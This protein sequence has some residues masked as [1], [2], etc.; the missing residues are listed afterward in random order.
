MDELVGPAP[1]GALDRGVELGESRAYPLGAGERDDGHGS[2]FPDQRG[3]PEPK[4][5]PRRPKWMHIATYDR[6]LE[7]WHEA[8]ER[9]DAIYDTK[10]AGFVARL[11]RLGE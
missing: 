7:S 3:H 2:A 4:I 9:R 8:G 1:L 6:L 5:P 11:D 10:I